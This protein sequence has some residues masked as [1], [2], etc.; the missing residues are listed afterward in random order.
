MHAGRIIATASRVISDDG[1]MLT[2]TYQ[3]MQLGAQ[4]DYIAVYDKQK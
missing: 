4:V 3:G 2:I 1:N